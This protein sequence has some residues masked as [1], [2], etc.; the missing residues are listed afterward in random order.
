MQSKIETP[1]APEQVDFMPVG[2]LAQRYIVSLN[3]QSA[4]MT[5][6]EF[7]SMLASSIAASAFMM[8]STNKPEDIKALFSA[9]VDDAHKQFEARKLAM[10]KAGH[11][12][13]VN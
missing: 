2:E 1:A 13:K 5:P 7:A 4:H 12:G 3:N 8:L 10:A 6:Q 9:C 11:V